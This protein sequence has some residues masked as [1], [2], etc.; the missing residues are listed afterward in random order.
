[1][2]KKTMR[3]NLELSRKFY[4]P[5]GENALRIM[6]V[7][8]RTGF[9]TICQ[10]GKCPNIGLCWSKLHATFMLLGDTCTRHCRF[11]A[12]K[13]GRP[14]PLTQEDWD[15]LTE[16]AEAI[17]EMN[18]RYVVITMVTRDDLDDGGASYMAEAVRRIKNISPNTEVE[19]LI[20]DLGGDM[21]ALET[22]LN[23]RPYVL[24]HNLE[25]VRRLTPLV[26]DRRASYERSLGVL[27]NSKEIAP[28]IITKSGLMVGL[29]ETMDELVEAMED[30]REVGVEALT[31][32]QY[33]QPTKRSYPVMKYYTDDEFAYLKEKALELGFKFVRSGFRVRSSFDASDI[34]KVIPKT[35]ART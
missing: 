7:L 22:V 8:K 18:L 25:T 35:K 13:S 29:G 17:R 6:D 15:K 27:K 32:G 26:R 4:Y 5:T 20:S 30:L 34:L 1:M 19:L 16:L 2:A 24:A 21:R 23:A 3:E 14:K 31:I 10:E 33:L 12:V 11:C 28:D 9:T